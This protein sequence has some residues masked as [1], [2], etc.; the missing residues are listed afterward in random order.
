MSKQQ[1]TPEERFAVLKEQSDAYGKMSKEIWCKLLPLLE[2]IQAKQVPQNK[3]QQTID[4]A[5]YYL[6]EFAAIHRDSEICHKGIVAIYKQLNHLESAKKI[7][8]SIEGRATTFNKILEGARSIGVTIQNPT[9]HRANSER[10]LQQTT[11][12][13]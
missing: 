9:Q 13:R 1:L 12:F 3:L 10:S 4:L 11:K 6:T 2:Q 8:K 5:S 7:E